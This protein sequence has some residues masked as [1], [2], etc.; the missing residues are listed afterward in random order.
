[1][2]DAAALENQWTAA[3][4]GGVPT[5]SGLVQARTALLI[6]RDELEALSRERLDLATSH[7]AALQRQ[8]MADLARAMEKEGGDGAADKPDGHE[9]KLAAELKDAKLAQRLAESARTAIYA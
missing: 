6:R 1:A 5:T 2:H 7:E 4:L 9:A 8:E 3:G